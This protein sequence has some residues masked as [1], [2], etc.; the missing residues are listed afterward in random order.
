MNSSGQIS[1]GRPLE[2]DC[3]GDQ[4]PEQAPTYTRTGR[5]TKFPPRIQEFDCGRLKSSEAQVGCIGIGRSS[6]NNGDNSISDHNDSLDE[7]LM[8]LRMDPPLAYA[9][10]D[11][12]LGARNTGPPVPYKGARHIGAEMI[13]LETVWRK[14]ESRLVVRSRE[15]RV[16]ES[17][18]AKRS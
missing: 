5:T 7:L 8:E 16:T 14:T 9:A 10:F 17:R 3:K 4:T 15:K 13:Q 2:A 6:E 18:L 1:N 11:A 12:A